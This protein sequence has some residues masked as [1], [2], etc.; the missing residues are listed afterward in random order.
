ELITHISGDFLEAIDW[1]RQ[2]G[3]DFK[4]TSPAYTVDD[5]IEDLNNKGYIV[6]RLD[7]RCGGGV[8]LHSKMEKVLPQNALNQIFGKM[9]KGK[10]G[11]HKTN[12]AGM[13]D[14]N[15]GD[16][17][18]YQYGDSLE[19]ISVTE[20][21]KNA[22]INHGIGDFSLSENDLVVEDTQFKS[23]MST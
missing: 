7:F 8:C 6:E 20:S 18:S 19:K 23:Q 21:L 4:L 2:L 1:L 17:R 10:S 3:K 22:Q 12:Y 11:N 15:T 16:F 14:E 5:F 9:R 13:S